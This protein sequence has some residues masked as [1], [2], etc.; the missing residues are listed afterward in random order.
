MRFTMEICKEIWYFTTDRAF[1][2]GIDN[3]PRMCGVMFSPLGGIQ[4]GCD[5]FVAKPRRL[6][7]RAWYK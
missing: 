7:V 3:R 4:S 6:D 2:C 1:K 5:F